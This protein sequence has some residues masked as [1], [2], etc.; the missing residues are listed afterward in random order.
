MRSRTAFTRKILMR[1]TRQHFMSQGEAN[2]RLNIWSY[3][4]KSKKTTQ[5]T[6]FEDFDIQ[7]KRI[8]EGETEVFNQLKS[9]FEARFEEIKS[10]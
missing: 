10:Q 8:Q 7:M 5:V 3:D 6:K 1:P 2:M 4:T 9:N